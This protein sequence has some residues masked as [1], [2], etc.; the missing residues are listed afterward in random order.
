MENAMIKR[1]LDA[2]KQN[3]EQLEKLMNE[4]GSRD[5]DWQV[6]LPIGDRCRITVKHGKITK[7]W[8][9]EQRVVNISVFRLK[10]T[11][12]HIPWE[13]FELPYSTLHALKQSGA[14]IN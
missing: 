4:N 12:F 5:G 13:D 8:G 9:A 14:V 7:V 1:I 2:W 6:Y 3:G 10:H 11:L